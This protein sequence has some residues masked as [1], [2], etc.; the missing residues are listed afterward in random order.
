LLIAVV[1]GL[2]LL[3][4]CGQATTTQD[5]PGVVAPADP[6]AAVA[7]APAD[8]RVAVAAWW[9]G[10][11]QDRLSAISKDI[12]DSG[13]A[14]AASDISGL[15]AAC[16][17]LQTDIEAAQAYEHVP[18]TLIQTDWSTTLAQYA[19]S[20]TDCIAATHNRDFDSFD[21]DL[22]AQSTR[23]MGAPTAAVRRMTDRLKTLQSGGG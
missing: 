19:R 10:G 3:A 6:R 5:T 18:D 13:A 4:G 12:D 1:I 9:T 14:A 21:P 8:P 7:V 15:S 17:S 23:E 20:A 11:G 22:L 16:A 2:I